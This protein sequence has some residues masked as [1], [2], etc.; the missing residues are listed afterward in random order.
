M[1]LAAVFSFGEFIIIPL[2][3]P[4]MDIWLG[5]NTITNI[6]VLTGV[7]FAVL[8]SLMIINSTLSSIAKDLR[9]FGRVFLRLN[10]EADGNWFSFNKRASYEEVGAFF[11]HFADIIHE[12][13]PNVLMI[14]CIDGVENVG[15]EKIKKEEAFAEAVRKADIWSVDKY[16]AFN[17]WRMCGYGYY[18]CLYKTC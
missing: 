6:N 12:E 14:I 10:H 4:L 1:I 2:M 7:C 11:A 16:M 9:T 17:W 5:E 8:G 3:K 18:R 13:A 15:D